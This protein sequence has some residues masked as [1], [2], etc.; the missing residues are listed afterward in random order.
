M[1]PRNLRDVTAVINKVKQIYFLVHMTL[2]LQS[3]N[4]AYNNHDN[5]IPDYSHAM[6]C[7]TISSSDPKLR[8]TIPCTVIRSIRSQIA[9]T[10]CR[11]QPLGRSDPKLQSRN[12]ENN[13]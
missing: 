8:S 5:F 12:A 13:R 6:P 2:T 4:V 9:V 11:V 7:T 10:Y 1:L 3:C